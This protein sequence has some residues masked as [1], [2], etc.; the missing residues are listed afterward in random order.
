MKAMGKPYS[1]SERIITADKFWIP[2]RT[3]LGGKTETHFTPQM[4]SI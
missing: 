2:C 3:G 4:L 1:I